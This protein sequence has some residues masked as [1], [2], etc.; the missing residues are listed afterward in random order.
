MSRAVK[1]GFGGGPSKDTL[2]LFKDRYLQPGTNNYN[3]RYDETDRES[4]NTFGRRQDPNSAYI[5]RTNK[6]MYAQQLADQIREQTIK[7]KSLAESRRM[8]EQVLLRQSLDN[9][10]YGREDVHSYNVRRGTGLQGLYG[11]SQK[12]SGFSPSPVYNSLNIQSRAIERPKNGFE[13]P[14]KRLVEKPYGMEPQSASPNPNYFLGSRQTQE[15]DPA[16]DRRQKLKEDW[17]KELND[18]RNQLAKRKEEEKRRLMEEELMY[19]EK[20]KQQLVELNRGLERDKDPFPGAREKDGPPSNFNTGSLDLQR[21]KETEEER[22]HQLLP[23]KSHEYHS[24]NPN[25]LYMFDQSAPRKYIPPHH[26]RARKAESE[27]QYESAML[28]NRIDLLKEEVLAGKRM[29]TQQVK[30]LNEIL[31]S[32]SD[33]LR[34]VKKQEK[35]ADQ[36]GSSHFPLYPNEL[37]NFALEKTNKNKLMNAQRS[38]EGGKPRGSAPFKFYDGKTGTVAEDLN[39]V[40]ELHENTNT[41]FLTSGLESHGQQHA[42]NDQGPQQPKVTSKSNNID[43]NQPDS[44]K[45]E[46]YNPDAKGMQTASLEELGNEIEKYTAIMNDKHYDRIMYPF[47]GRRDPDDLKRAREIHLDK[48]EKEQDGLKKTKATTSSE[49]LDYIRKVD[50]VLRDLRREIH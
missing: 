43:Q 48:V 15:T 3:T 31:E 12:Q 42:L 44:E 49:D 8:E 25:E 35:R 1:V 24:F 38:Y 13:S 14:L 28:Q 50:D 7:K 26:I 2:D 34:Q 6:E 37:G 9:Y 21:F 23:Y 46:S 47:M 19:E 32:S 11:S 39:E 16:K 20:F 5:S 30:E 33:Q 45:T 41:L 10:P 29:F 27:E 4:A 36:A 22:L 17:I 18:Q 40:E